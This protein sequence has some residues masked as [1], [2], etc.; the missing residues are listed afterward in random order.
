VKE[1]NLK[2]VRIK[3]NELLARWRSAE[4]GKTQH[5]A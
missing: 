4:A 2:G 5:A 3:W 1:N